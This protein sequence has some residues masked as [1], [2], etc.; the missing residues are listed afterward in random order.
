MFKPDEQGVYASVGASKARRIFGLFAL[1]TLGAL[2]LLM[3]ARQPPVPVLAVAMLIL[4]A[5]AIWAGERL[6]RATKNRLVLLATEL[7]TSDGLLVASIDNIEKVERG[8]FAFKPSNGFTL[9]L[10]ERSSRIWQ[11]GLWWRSGRRVGVGGVVPSGEAKFMAEV[12]STWI[13]QR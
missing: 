7:R 3:V 2:V 9:V 13:A 5:G 1:Y 10:K 4:G 8:A 6:R 12:I 11:P